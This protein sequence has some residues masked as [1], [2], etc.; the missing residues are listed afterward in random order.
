MNLPQEVL[1]EVSPD[2]EHSRT[3]YHF[4]RKDTQRS[5]LTQQ[6]SGGRIERMRTY[7][8]R[9]FVINRLYHLT[10]KRGGVVWVEEHDLCAWL[11]GQDIET[12]GGA[13]TV[14]DRIKFRLAYWFFGVKN[15]SKL[16]NKISNVVAHCE[17]SEVNWIKSSKGNDA[18]S[19]YIA[20]SPKGEENY[21]L[22]SLI[23]G[24]ISNIRKLVLAVLLIP[25][26]AHWLPAILGWL[27]KII[28][29]LSAIGNG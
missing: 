3:I 11:S 5:P 14:L 7:L 13:D 10:R 9:W 15:H 19:K 12:H 25:A 21:A 27:V 8:H 18:V 29:T 16:Y 4:A 1:S 24:D 20:L 22:S 26:V 2:R 23:F 28:N 17:S 6:G